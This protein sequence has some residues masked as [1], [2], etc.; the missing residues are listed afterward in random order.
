MKKI[1]MRGGLTTVLLAGMLT[2]LYATHSTTATSQKNVDASVLFDEHCDSCHGKDGQAKT[3]KAKF[4]HARNLTDS[5]WQAE[6]TDE[7]L[8]NSISNGKGKMPAF[9]KKLSEAEINGLVAHVRRLK[10]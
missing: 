1:L 4:N 6:V 2:L 3:F 7:R 5:K 9:G 10:K 8:F